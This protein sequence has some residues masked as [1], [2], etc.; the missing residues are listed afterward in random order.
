MWGH[1]GELSVVG[2]DCNNFWVCANGH[3]SPSQDRDQIG[4]EFRGAKPTAV[5]GLC[6][7]CS[8]PTKLVIRG[9]L[10]FRNVWE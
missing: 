9:P 5:G 10:S 2:E 7:E 3:T 6:K 1:L 8:L 4:L